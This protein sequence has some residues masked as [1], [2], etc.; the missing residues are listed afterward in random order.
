MDLK[1]INTGFYFIFGELFPS[2]IA[3][4]QMK[5]VTRETE[6]G[7][8]FGTA[9]LSVHGIRGIYEVSNTV[10]DRLISSDRTLKFDARA[11]TFIMLLPSARFIFHGVLARFEIF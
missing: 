8:H 3:R 6:I 5:S 7:C 9:F 2:T 4:I 10:D 11:C 1:Y